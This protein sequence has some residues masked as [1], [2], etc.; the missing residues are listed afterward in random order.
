MGFWDSEKG[1]WDPVGPSGRKTVPEGS[2]G[3]NHVYNRNCRRVK[4][5]IP[6]MVPLG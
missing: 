2:T 5:L 4:K 6:G 3:G 1:G